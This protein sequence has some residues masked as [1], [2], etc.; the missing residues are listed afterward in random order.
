MWFI[1]DGAEEPKE[2]TGS[3]THKWD[4]D[5]FAEGVYLTMKCLIYSGG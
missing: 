5:R 1:D 4:I 3:K 2:H